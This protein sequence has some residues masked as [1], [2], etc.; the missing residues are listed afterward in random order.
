[1]AFCSAVSGLENKKR[2]KKIVVV[3]GEAALPPTLLTRKNITMS[4]PLV[5]LTVFLI[6]F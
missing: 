3:F 2:E 6:G 5:R 1:M 4:L